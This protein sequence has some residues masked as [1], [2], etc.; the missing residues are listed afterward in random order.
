MLSTRSGLK[1][2][3]WSVLSQ[4]YQNGENKIE[5]FC[6]KG[7]TFSQLLFILCIEAVTKAI[8]YRAGRDYNDFRTASTHVHE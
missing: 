2:T 5:L 7:L 8:K 3:S 1:V 4:S 6:I